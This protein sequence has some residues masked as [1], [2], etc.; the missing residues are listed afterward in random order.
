[1]KAI[2]FDRHGGPEVLTYT[3]VADPCPGPGEVLIC[4]GALT[5]NPG[6]DVMTREGTFGLPGFGLPH[7]GGS[8][9]AGEVVA[10]GDGV[11][12]P[13][14]GDRVVVYPV[15]SCGSCDFCQ[16]GSGENHCENW[17]LW[18]AQTWGG[19]AELAKVPAAN[20]VS[21]PESVSWEAAA[22]LP[23]TYLTAW[24]GLVD[25]AGVNHRDTVLVLGAAGGVGV[26]AI[27][28]ARVFGARVIAVTGQEWKR[29][30]ALEVGAHYALDYREQGWPD[31]VREITD[32]RG[33]TVVFDNVGEAT[34]AQSVPC[35]ARAGR[36]VCSGA[37]TG[38]KLTL[39]ARWAYRN[40]I[41]LHFYMLGTRR[42]LEQLVELVAD[43]SIDPVIDSRFALGDIVAAER[44]LAAQDHFG[45][46]VLDPTLPPV[47]GAV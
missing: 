46:I 6:P 39:D 23:V 34:W 17:R 42:N 35:L 32:R 3:N 28:I 9:P 24:H 19:R 41:S 47:G 25:C 8:D 38:D 18:G 5:V 15:L 40:M 30:R 29:A 31:R 44:K 2:I 4:I 16:P 10:V 37:T 27:Q 45:K 20:V 36:F 26:A 43:R 13:Q 14:V 12:T 1:M 21:V 7:I 11:T 33:A 22:A